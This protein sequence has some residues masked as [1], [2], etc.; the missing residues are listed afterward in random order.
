MLALSA[1]M[2]AKHHEES[3]VLLIVV[4]VAEDTVDV[5]LTS[6][7]AVLPSFRVVDVL[8]LAFASFLE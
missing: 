3:H 4:V 8:A 5:V 2:M 7:V 1:N 6:L